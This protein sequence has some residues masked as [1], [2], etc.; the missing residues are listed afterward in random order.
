MKN[1]LVVLLL[2]L[3]GLFFIR[4][5]YAKEE[6]HV[7]AYLPSWVNWE[8]EDIDV[9]SLTDLNFSFLEIK[10]GKVVFGK[11]SSK[12]KFEENIEKLQILKIINPNMKLIISVG[13]WGIDGFSDAALTPES[14]E[15]FAESIVEFLEKYNFDGVDIDW[16]FP[17]TGGAENIKHNPNDKENFVLLIEEIRNQLNIL[18][19]TNNKSY[20]LSIAVGV[21]SLV[22]DGI[23]F[24]A[25]ELNVDYFGIMAYNLS[26]IWSDKTKSH[27]A[28]YKGDDDWSISDAVEKI[29]ATGVI[30][31]KLLLGV[32][33]YGRPM[34]NVE[35]GSKNGLYQNFTGNG[36]KNS[37]TYKYIAENYLNN[38]DYKVFFDS[39][40]R[41]THIYS[42]KEKLFVS[43]QD[44]KSIKEFVKYVKKNHLAGVLIWEI[45]QDD[46][47]K[48]LLKSINK[49]IH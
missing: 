26:G 8:I 1:F 6:Y 25:M 29:L 42:K 41:A 16:E 27:V 35:E 43:Y 20:S 34:G 17:V 32:A 44:P 39:K 36:G 15:I 9:S 10:D 28:L 4:W 48:T 22:T 2:G 23:D 7:V 18:E 30:S 12:Y 33:F 45:T 40:T 46:N 21:G 14:R 3:L 11:N 19:Q 38:K 13:G 37:A 31:R 49:Y 24:K 47:D 5:S